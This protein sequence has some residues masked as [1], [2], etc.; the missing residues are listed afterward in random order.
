MDIE[1]RAGRSK[2]NR[3][4]KELTGASTPTRR[5]EDNEIRS[6]PREDHRLAVRASRAAPRRTASHRVAPP[7]DT[8]SCRAPLRFSIFHFILLFFLPRYESTTLRWVTRG[9]ILFPIRGFARKYL[10][11]STYPTGAYELSLDS[12]RA[13]LA[14]ALAGLRA[15]SVTHAQ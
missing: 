9:Q 5:S 7:S 10:P 1:G 13:S 15:R 14:L 4:R 11:H 12:L 2:S 3:A 6:L 8:I